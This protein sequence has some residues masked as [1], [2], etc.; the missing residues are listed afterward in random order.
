[1]LGRLSPSLKERIIG[2]DA[3]AVLAEES[4]LHGLLNSMVEIDQSAYS[5][6]LE[7][8]ALL[9]KTIGLAPG[10]MALIINGRVRDILI[11]S[12]MSLRLAGQVLGPIERDGFTA[13]DFESLCAYELQRR[14]IPVM[15]ALGETYPAL[16]EL[17]KSVPP[18]V[19]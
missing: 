1:M 11:P 3:Q 2:A 10:E 9:S 7:A 16:D 6:H 17:E 13:P 18:G 12:S 19:L 4:S 15:T 8:S 5:K 14:V